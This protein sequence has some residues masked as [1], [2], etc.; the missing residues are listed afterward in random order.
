MRKSKS[1]V[2]IG[3]GQT[4]NQ[5]MDKGD[6]YR[7]SDGNENYRKSDGNENYRQ[8]MFES[9]I[10]NNA[11]EES[12]YHTKKNSLKNNV[13]PIHISEY[14]SNHKRKDSFNSSQLQQNYNYQ[15]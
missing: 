15:Q 12:K 8:S 10:H 1:N 4:V 3:V 6:N 13:G 2:K 7:K 9:N 14:R 5:T 11:Y